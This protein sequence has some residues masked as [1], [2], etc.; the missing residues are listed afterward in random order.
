MIKTR[1]KISIGKFV[2]IK[3]ISHKLI[4]R[5]DVKTSPKLNTLSTAVGVDVES[6]HE[7]IIDH[8]RPEGA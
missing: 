6:L 4:N 8:H 1:Q 7:N 5:F 2:L 3:E